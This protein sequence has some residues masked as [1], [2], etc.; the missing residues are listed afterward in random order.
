MFVDIG[1]LHATIFVAQYHSGGIRILYCQ[2]L[3]GCSG[4]DFDKVLTDMVYEQILQENKIDINEEEFRPRDRMSILS[5]CEKT[6]QFLGVNGLP[7]H[8][9]KCSIHSRDVTVHF[10]TSQFNEKA[11]PIMKHLKKACKNCLVA[12]HTQYRDE[13]KIETAQ[14]STISIISSPRPTSPSPS[15]SP[16]RRPISTIVLEGSSS[17]FQCVTNAMKQVVKEFTKEIE[18]S[19]GP[20]GVSSN[21]RVRIDIK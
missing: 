11:E 3:E 8:D 19:I 18:S 20:N 13:M 9:L 5:Q 15:S 10:T 14:P 2:P 17:R 16:K 12:M 1:Y 6:K 4:R 7:D 21:E